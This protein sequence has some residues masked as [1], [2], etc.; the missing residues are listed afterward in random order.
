MIVYFVTI[1]MRLAWTCAG[2]TSCYTWGDFIAGIS[3]DSQAPYG[4][5]H[6][7]RVWQ[8]SVSGSTW[9]ENPRLTVQCHRFSSPSNRRFF[10]YIGLHRAAYVSYVKTASRIVSYN[11]RSF[12]EREGAFP[13]IFPGIHTL[14][15]FHSVLFYMVKIYGS[16]GV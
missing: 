13:S 6:D 2:S 14:A 15:D 9:T 8:E 10:T 1:I 5:D 7:D 4:D 3:T 11:V 12:R 16:Y